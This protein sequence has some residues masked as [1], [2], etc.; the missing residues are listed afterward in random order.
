MVQN[1]IKNIV[2]DKISH[3]IVTTNP[4]NQCITRH[5]K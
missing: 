2:K 5:L 4:L 1:N 3:K